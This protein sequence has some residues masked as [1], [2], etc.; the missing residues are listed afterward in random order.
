M[1]VCIILQQVGL[2]K[3]KIK[4]CI[5]ISVDHLSLPNYKQPFFYVVLLLLLLLVGFFGT[6]VS[7]KNTRS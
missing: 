6:I 5:S 7:H 1:Q 4:Q 3:K 2:N